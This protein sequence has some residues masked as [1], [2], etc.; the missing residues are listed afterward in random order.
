MTAPEAT[1]APTASTPAPLTTDQCVQEYEK[2]LRISDE[3]FA[4]TH[5]RL[6]VPQQFVRKVPPRSSQKASIAPAQV[7]TSGPSGAVSEKKSQHESVATGPAPSQAAYSANG[8]AV[9]TPTT[10]PT[11]T[12]HIVPKPTSE[13]DPIFLTKS[14]D[15]VRAELQLQRQRVERVLREQL[16][17]KRLESRYKASL[18]DSKPDFDVSDVLNRALEIVKPI[19]PDD[20]HK[21]NGTALPS[22]SLDGNS[23]YSSRAPDSPQHREPQKPSP[24]SERHALPSTSDEV[25]T[26]VPVDQYSDELRRLEALNPSGSDQEMR[27][28]FS[29]ADQHLPHQ[30]QAHAGQVDSFTERPRAVQQHAEVLEESEYSPP[31]PDVPPM[32][33]GDSREY[34]KGL[35]NNARQRAPDRGYRT[36]RSLSPASDV[37]I[38]RNHITSPAAP[39]PSRVSPL[40]ISTGPSS[41]QPRYSRPEYTRREPASGRASPDIPAQQLMPRKRRRVHDERDHPVFYRRPA[42]D[43]SGTYI[44]EEPVSP[45][46]FAD[47]P[48][49]PRTRPA[50]ERPIY[51]DI[52]SPRYTPV[53]DRR[54]AP[55]REPVYEYD[56]YTRAP[57]NEIHVEPAIPRAVSRVSTRRPMR[58][59]QDLRRVASL[60]QLRQ[61]ELSRDYVDYPAPGSMRASSY[62][63]VERPAP[64]RARYYEEPA[65]VYTRRYI[66]VDEPSLPPRYRETYI[67]EELP[68]PIMGPPQRRIVVDEHGN[69]YYETVHAPPR[70]Q[71]V[72]RP[73]TQITK[74]EVYDDR[75][76]TRAASVRAASIVED[77]YGERRYVQE[78]PPPPPQVTYRRAADYTQP[79]LGERR[80]YAPAIDGREAFPRSASVQVADYPRR[81]AYVEEP[82]VPRE[83][84]VRMS[85]VRP[86]HTRY[87]E[88]REVGV[89]VDDDARR[90][91]D[92]VERPVYVSTTRPMR[93]ERYY[94]DGN[95]DRMVIDGGRPDVAQAQRVPPRY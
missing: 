70:L 20:V 44:K 46:P 40:A 80:G 87:D 76:P 50:P 22:D 2:I 60:N 49:A 58:D 21:P 43:S 65:P 14:D 42:V 45:P 73:A 29:V 24:E 8:A 18:M 78:M 69:Q 56:P 38:V 95:P 39:Q 31:A 85:S 26:D 77:A 59:D 7:A 36:R 12:A 57:E 86:V 48:P 53:A 79:A 54:E 64:E 68:A 94:E 72:S 63:V 5:P 13:I 23:F 16:E 1:Q 51:I 75:V 25:A 71:P 81:T 35:P 17:Q 28:T 89:Y 83:R 30:R 90:P 66:P 37:R 27:D 19:G 15:L 93:E 47:T 62:A 6:K 4:G 84:L 61:P 32:A 11:S 9:E 10:A 33:K 74:P 55:V 82:E 67:E 41:Q 91:R 34:H 88:P 3:V 52:A 92:Y